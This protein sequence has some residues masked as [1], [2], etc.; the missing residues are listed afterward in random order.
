M[1]Q[2]RPVSVWQAVFLAL[3]LAWA[4]LCGFVFGG[5]VVV[6]VFFAIAAPAQVRQLD[7]F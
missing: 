3:Y 7:G 2:R 1:Q 6:L 4:L 5:R